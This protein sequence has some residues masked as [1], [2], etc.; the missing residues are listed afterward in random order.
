[1]LKDL[2]LERQ[3]R[4]VLEDVSWTIRPGQRWV[5]AGGNGAGKTQLLKIIGGAVWPSA[6]EGKSPSAV[7]SSSRRYHWRNETFRSP[8]EVKEEIGYVG[9]ERQDKYERYGWNHSVEQ[10]VGTG[11][12]RT[13]I[14][15]NPLTADDRRK[16][17][18]ML[19]RLAI[20]PLAQRS[21]LSLSYGERRLTL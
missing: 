6:G 8:F 3:G 5:L 21:F 18:A 20:A 2:A 4:K 12:Y 9:P 1:R 11:L 16:I 17:D 15:L 14:P 19:S 10:I 7:A 13:D